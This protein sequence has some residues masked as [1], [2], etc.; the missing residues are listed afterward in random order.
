MKN[1]L[2]IASLILVLTSCEKESFQKNSFDETENSTELA[3]NYVKIFLKDAQGKIYHPSQTGLTGLFAQNLDTGKF[4]YPKGK[5]RN[6]NTSDVFEYLPDGTYTFTAYDGYFDGAGATTL[7]ID[8]NVIL[9]ENGIIEV[10][11]NYWSE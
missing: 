4:F 1:L 3:G 7:T 2:F 11:L 6:N 5:H 10:F 9:N 8:E